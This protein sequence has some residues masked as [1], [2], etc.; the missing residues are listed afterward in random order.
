METARMPG[1]EDENED[2]FDDIAFMPRRHMFL[3][4]GGICAALLAVAGLWWGLA[5]TNKNTNLSFQGNRRATD[6]QPRAANP[7]RESSY[8]DP[9]SPVGTTGA[10]SGQPNTSTAPET[11]LDL[12]GLLGA[13][14]ATTLI[15][16]RVEVD[17]PVLQAHN[18]TTFWIGDPNDR[19]LVVL[20]R[21]TRDGAERQ[22]S[23]PPEH[24]IVP[25]ENG[26][27]ASIRGTVQGV[28]RAE[29]RYNWDL[30]ATQDRE[31]KRK[32]VFI[33]ADS[34]RTGGS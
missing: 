30:T 22:A 29:E 19:L 23:K 8:K 9:A 32:G 10:P 25:A 14:D 3:K 24:G 12:K 28:P 11:I 13:D 16:R 7:L 31:L 20:G 21:D 26:Q 4:L 27:Q 15:G 5:E 33:L 18:P 1:M 34:A 17:V 2:I 6:I